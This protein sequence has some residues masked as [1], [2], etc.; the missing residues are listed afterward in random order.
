MT[1]SNFVKTDKESIKWF[2]LH[3]S[4]HE[5]P[6]SLHQIEEKLAAKVISENIKVWTEGLR[7]PLTLRT[8]LA[9]LKETDFP[10]ELPPPIPEVMP[11]PVDAPLPPVENLE[12]KNKWIWPGFMAVMM[13]AVL[14]SVSFFWIK[15]SEHFD[16]RRYPKMSL[17]L[18]Q[19]IQNQET[20]MF[21][22]WGK[23]IFFKEFISDDLTR[24]WLITS[25]YQTCDVEADFQ[26]LPER[27][28]SR[29]DK[30]VIAFKTKGVLK[31]H[32]VE[33]SNFY[34]SKGEK[35]IPGLYEMNIEANNCSWDGLRAKLA[36]VF[37][38]AEDVYKA[39]IKVV[40]YPKGSE[41]FYKILK[42][43][44]D[45]KFMI[46]EQNKQKEEIFWQDLQ[47]KFQTLLA[48]T[49]QIEQHFL[50]FI[51]MDSRAFHENLKPMTNR[52]AEKYGQ[53]L[54]S[55]VLGNEEYFKKLSLQ[56][57]NGLSNK[58][59]FEGLIRDT[60]KA[61]GFESMKV[62]EHFQT[63]KGKVWRKDLEL[64][65]QKLLKT[66]SR[67]KNNINQKIIQIGEERVKPN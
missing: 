13:M 7:E 44:V 26:S 45:K 57:M 8:V 11:T 5:G 51:A 48:I 2:L 65:K 40:L 17:E 46:L 10:D 42:K 21:S 55:F 33:F 62:I 15:S 52:Y 12:K 36:N 19:K 54:T 50:D 9:E 35:L 38:S 20:F 16:I 3:L 18:H 66:F 67:L 29:D 22:G 4:G 41:E 63:M 49:I 27:L 31:D 34:F 39:R 58:T 43:F 61:V 47:Q 56:E 60:S 14:F 28:L 1:L 59:K 24:I 23:E 37:N 6:Y 64:E 53:F 32:V 25:S 30:A